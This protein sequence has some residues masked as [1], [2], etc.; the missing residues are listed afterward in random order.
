MR[1]LTFCAGTDAFTNSA[2]G[3]LATRETV[4]VYF[5]V[6]KGI[7]AITARLIARPE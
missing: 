5:A 6:S 7:L 3:T 4:P 2:I 1:P